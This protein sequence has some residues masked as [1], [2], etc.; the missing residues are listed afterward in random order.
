MARWIWLA[1]A[2]GACGHDTC[3]YGGVTYEEGD[4]FPA[5]DGCNTCTCEKHGAVSCTEMGCLS[6]S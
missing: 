3:E 5:D 2:L 1:A 6:S 4:T